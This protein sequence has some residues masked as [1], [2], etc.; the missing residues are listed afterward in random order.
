MNLESWDIVED[1]PHRIWDTLA[2]RE[3]IER[4]LKKLVR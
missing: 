2:G 1:A 3:V 4:R